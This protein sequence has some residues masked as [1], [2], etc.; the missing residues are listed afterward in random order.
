VI[1]KEELL[2]MKSELFRKESVEKITSPEDLN[3][4]VKVLNPRVWLILAG[5]AIAIIGLVI[6]AASTGYPIW[7]LFFGNTGV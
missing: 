4:Y 3:T 1:E 2:A 7:D 6:F 5:I